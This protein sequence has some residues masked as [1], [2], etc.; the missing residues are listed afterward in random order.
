MIQ[1]SNS[2]T[3]TKQLAEPPVVMQ[4]ASV[5]VDEND[6]ERHLDCELQVLRRMRLALSSTLCLLE[7]AR[8]DLLQSSHEMDQLAVASERVRKAFAELKKL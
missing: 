3:N 1:H 4:P 2:A 8:D 7:A 5:L 6:E